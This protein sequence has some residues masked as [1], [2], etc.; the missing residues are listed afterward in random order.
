[1]PRPAEYVHNLE[2]A[3]EYLQRVEGQWIDRATLEE[4]MSVNK[5]RAWQLMKK[6]GAVP[7]PGNTLILERRLA[8]LGLSRLAAGDDTARQVER[9]AKLVGRLEA[10]AK[11]TFSRRHMIVRDDR[12]ALALRSQRFSS[13][14][15]AVLLTPS[16]LEITFHG[17]EDFLRQLGA[18]I[19]A[20]Q[21][22]FAAVEK[23]IEGIR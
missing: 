3:I 13:L 21:N 17:T 8:I 5:T 22:D 23:F 14:P 11:D 9:R 16:K 15:S 7:G 4:A 12:E 1:M 2:A 6:F 20:V 18:V 19:F 10:V